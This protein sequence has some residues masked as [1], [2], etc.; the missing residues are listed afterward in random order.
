MDLRRI[1]AEPL[2]YR[3]FSS[4][5]GSDS[6]TRR[7]LDL[8]LPELDSKSVLDVG[9]GPRGVVA[10]LPKSAR[11]VGVDSSRKYCEAA[12][13]FNQ[14]R[15]DFICAQAECLPDSIGKFDVIIASGLLHHLSD[16]NARAFLGQMSQFL[17]KDGVLLTLDGVWV[18]NQS[19][20]A[21]LL[22]QC[23]RGDHVRTLK[24]YVALAEQPI[25]CIGSWVLNDLL[26]IPY[27]HAILKFKIDA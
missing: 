21:R 24:Q 7:V 2:G 9:C 18:A 14:S 25:K 6:A 4:I 22:L 15:G 16:E 1:L 10:Y 20:L 27:S 19:M 11:Y 3:L 8:Y 5:V 26:R 13:R 23:D 12:R 17:Q